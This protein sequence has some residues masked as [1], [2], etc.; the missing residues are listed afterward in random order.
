MIDAFKKRGVATVNIPGAFLL[1]K[2]PKGE[3]NVYVI[4]D[5]RM[6]E[7]LANIAP[8]TYQEYIHQRRIQA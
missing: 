8:K 7:L 6:A 2:M 3:D 1:T 5:G 4:L